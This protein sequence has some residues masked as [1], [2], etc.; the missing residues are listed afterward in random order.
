MTNRRMTNRQTAAA[1]VAAVAAVA[2]LLVGLRGLDGAWPRAGAP[3]SA[4]AAPAAMR[5]V[6]D[7][8]GRPVV[9]TPA[10]ALAAGE[11]RQAPPPGALQARAAARV[12]T[13]PGGGEMVLLEGRA[14]H[15]LRVERAGD[16]R[17]AVGCQDGERDAR[18]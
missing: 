18:P 7:D 13:A 3:P 4:A 10:G 14:A 5:V 12:E 6:L 17:L 2:A 8:A 16:G 9:P 1:A 11:P 15:H